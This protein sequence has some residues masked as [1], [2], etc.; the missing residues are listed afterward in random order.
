MCMMSSGKCNRTAECYDVV[1]I[2]N[3][4]P[5]DRRIIICAEVIEMPR[6]PKSTRDRGL[7]QRIE[8]LTDRDQQHWL[9]EHS[10]ATHAP[11]GDILRRAV[12]AYRQ[13]IERKAA[14]QPKPSAM[15]AA[16]PLECVQVMDIPVP[17]VE[18]ALPAKV[19]APAE[20]PA[21]PGY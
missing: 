15:P 9:H 19:A 5:L 12:E 4:R 17:A 1:I 18:P 13:T 14:K 16:E 11:L 10:R 21:A 7:Q 2:W 6:R 20:E 8:F 3:L